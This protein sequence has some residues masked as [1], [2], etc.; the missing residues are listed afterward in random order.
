MM[1]T[2]KKKKNWLKTR[3]RESKRIGNEKYM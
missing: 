2:L 1:T 3:N